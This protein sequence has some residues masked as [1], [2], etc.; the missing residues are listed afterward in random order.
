MFNHETDESVTCY[1]SCNNEQDHY[2]CMFVFLHVTLILS[3]R[4]QHRS[5][6]AAVLYELTSDCNYLALL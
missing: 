6:Q 4:M 5:Y 2:Y 1:E 3:F